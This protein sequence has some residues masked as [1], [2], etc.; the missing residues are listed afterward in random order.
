[1]DYDAVRNVLLPFNRNVVHG[2][3]GLI[4]ERFNS[5]LEILRSNGFVQERGDCCATRSELLHYVPP[6]KIGQ[7]S[8]LSLGDQT[9]PILEPAL[10]SITQYEERVTRSRSASI[11]TTVRYRRRNAEQAEEMVY[12]L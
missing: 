12:S 5:N 6:N 4:R 3:L 9:D 10:G 11:Q 1:V 8:P 7:L 2:N